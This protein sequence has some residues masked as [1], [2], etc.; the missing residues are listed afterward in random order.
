M[1]IIIDNLGMGFFRNKLVNF[2]I[3]K[4]L[5]HVTGP[6]SAVIVFVKREN[7]IIQQG[8]MEEKNLISQI[9]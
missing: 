6:G 4:N 5:T 7:K 2:Y 1:M 9:V 3:K 8:K